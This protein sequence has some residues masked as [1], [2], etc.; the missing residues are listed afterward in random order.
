MMKITESKDGLNFKGRCIIAGSLALVLLLGLVGSW[1][2][3][4]NT[5][6]TTPADSTVKAVGN[7]S[8]D[9]Y[10]SALQYEISKYVSDYFET[11]EVSNY[12]TKDNLQ[13]V[14]DL[15]LASLEENGVFNNVT[16]VD[17]TTIKNLIQT[18]LKDVLS[19]LDSDET[20]ITDLKNTLASI[21]TSK[22]TDAQVKQI[23][24][25]IHELETSE[26][27]DG[28]A[29]K[30]EI[31]NVL[32]TEVSKV[33]TSI[34][35]LEK[36]L[37]DII[38]KNT[39]NALSED[40]LDAL[41]TQLLQKINECSDVDHSDKAELISMI[42]ALDTSTSSSLAN[43]E[44]KLTEVIND[45]QTTVN[46]ELESVWKAIDNLKVDTSVSDLKTELVTTVNNY[47]DIQESDKAELTTLINELRSSSTTELTDLDAKFAALIE[48]IQSTHADDKTAFLQALESLRTDLSAQIEEN[49]NQLS[50]L[51]A[52]VDNTVKANLISRINTVESELS[53][54]LD[55]LTDVQLVAL[56]STLQEQIDAQ[57]ALSAANKQELQSAID[58]L[59]IEQTSNLY[60][61]KKYLLEYTD[62]LNS[63][64]EANLQSMISDLSV[65]TDTN[66]ANTK[67]ELIAQVVANS[68]ADAETKSQLI[69]LINDLHDTVDANDTSI[70]AA[71]SDAV[72]DQRE[73]LNNAVS[74]LTVDITTLTERVSILETK[75]SD[76]TDVQLVALKEELKSD[77]ESAKLLSE[78]QKAELE[79]SIENLSASTDMSLTKLKSE[80]TATIDTKTA[81]NAKALN[82]FI[83][84][85]YGDADKSVTI[86]YLLGAIESSNSYTDSQKEYLTELIN[87]KFAET[88]QSIADVQAALSKEIADRT[89]TENTISSTIDS[90]LSEVNS[91]ISANKEAQDT[92]NSNTSALYQE[93]LERVGEN[94]DL[95]SATKAEIISKLE[96]LQSD[97]TTSL[98]DLKTELESAIQ[99]ASDANSQ[100][101]QDFIDALYD[102]ADSDMTIT[103]LLIL[104]QNTNDL[105]NRNKNELTEIINTNY[106]NQNVSIN[107]IQDSLNQEIADRNTAIN[108]VISELS[109]TIDN[110]IKELN[111]TIVANKT[112]QEAVNATL[113]NKDSEL[114]S[115][116]DAI[117]ESID[118]N[119]SDWELEVID[120]D[121]WLVKHKG[122]ADEFSKKLTY[123][124]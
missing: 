90:K 47:K 6:N 117:Q 61:M 9:E 49:T 20:D 56:K 83:S 80:L 50:A 78:T 97:T 4:R 68:N 70:K 104:I 96:T 17:T 118:D 124:Q 114:S 93:L 75:V 52:Y 59:D 122:Q 7:Y 5:N 27:V 119:E 77:V 66:L 105:T 107:T 94:E 8:D 111:D 51:K 13:D 73:A 53:T 14:V 84:E 116:I 31:Y 48:D 19:R 37:L 71:L 45:N 21:D 74:N 58:T 42:N 79:Q 100:E 38:N 33:N 22:L 101:L 85:L 87:S 110:K 88:S 65:A 11:E 112:E 98:S 24:S 46:T 40:D 10:L 69:G 63:N 72:S 108:N 86:E 2:Y 113:S 60:E 25:I 35:E 23:N 64:T 30:K 12:L 115:R 102:G 34:T 43:L 32:N 62:T 109:S 120:D 99:T 82:T 36:N 15:V 44:T 67:T 81:E 123:A 91:T 29:L 18:E 55:N 3:I 28:T 95:S 41:K 54:R 76:L 103:Q 89:N 121:V 39:E 16:N 1:L 26:K 57:T 106:S 92:I